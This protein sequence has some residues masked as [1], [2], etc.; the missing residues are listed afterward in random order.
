MT[1]PLEQ[2]KSTNH[3][4]T[5][6]RNIQGGPCFVIGCAQRLA[7][8]AGINSPSSNNVCPL[9]LSFKS[10]STY[11]SFSTS[12]LFVTLLRPGDGQ[13]DPS[14]SSRF[15]ADSLWSTGLYVAVELHTQYAGVKWYVSQ[16]AGLCWYLKGDGGVSINCF[17]CPW[18]TWTNA[19]DAIE[20]DQIPI[21]TLKW[22][23]R[24]ILSLNSLVGI[25]R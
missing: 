6:K 9:S 15:A 5:G 23:R 22:Y 17:Q 12:T 24:S 8:S 25:K 11:P 4:A 7:Y 19:L 13:N 10:T 3:K 21:E 2:T 1:R 18:A 20:V 14:S 16:C